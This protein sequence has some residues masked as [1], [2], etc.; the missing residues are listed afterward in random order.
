[1]AKTPKAYVRLTRSMGGVGT[2]Q[3]LWLGKDHLMLVTSTG[4]NES[5]ARLQFSDI[6][7]FFI[8]KSDR[9]LGWGIAWGVLAALFLVIV[10][11]H[12]VN[13]GR[14]GP[15]EDFPVISLIF[16]MI[17]TG[18]FLWNH[19]LGPGCRAFVVTGVQTAKLPSMVRLN[20]ARRVLG[21]LQPLIEAAQADLV[22]AAPAAPPLIV[23]GQSPVA[24]A[25]GAPL[26]TPEPVAPSPFQPEPPPAPAP[27]TPPQT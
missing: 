6:K 18:A 21:R 1:M 9:R 26:P 11:A 25:V 7:G 15:G 16:L 19:F 20:K 24:A 22:G 23:P 5:Y 4:Y 3:S 27:L 14:G 12:F 17:T 2:Y 13:P 10:A 8:T